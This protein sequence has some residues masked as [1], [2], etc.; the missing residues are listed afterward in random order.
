MSGRCLC[1]FVGQ[2]DRFSSGR[3]RTGVCRSCIPISCQYMKMRRWRTSQ[4]T[5]Q[6]G[7]TYS[8]MVLL[9]HLHIW[10]IWQAFLAHRREVGRLP[11]GA[12]QVLLDLRRHGGGPLSERKVERRLGRGDPQANRGSVSVESEYAGVGRSKIYAVQRLGAVSN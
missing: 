2:C 9:E 7:E 6:R 3:L 5:R 11:A 12:I 10:V 4:R 8:S 1:A